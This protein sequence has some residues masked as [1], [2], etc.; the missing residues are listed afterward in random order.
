MINARVDVKSTVVVSG[1]EVP[2]Y[3]G[4]DVEALH[5]NHGGSEYLGHNGVCQNI[6]LV[7]VETRGSIKQT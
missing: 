4:D 7:L 2:W 5:A 3:V 1:W 6:Q